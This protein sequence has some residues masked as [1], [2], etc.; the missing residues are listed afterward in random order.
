MKTVCCIRIIACCLVAFVVDGFDG[1]TGWSCTGCVLLAFV[2]VAA[3]VVGH[4]C[5]GSLVR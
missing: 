1:R 5:A 4:Q 2:V 3:Q